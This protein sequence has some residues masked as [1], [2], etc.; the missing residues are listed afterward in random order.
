MDGESDGYFT[1]VNDPGHP[2]LKVLVRPRWTLAPPEGIGSVGKSKTPCPK[3]YGETKDNCPITMVLL[4]CWTWWRAKQ[5]GFVDALAVRRTWYQ[6]EL[7]DV[8]DRLEMVEF[9]GSEGAAGARNMIR[10]WLPEALA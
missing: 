8:I 2:N 4:K 6:N 7:R 5:G 10:D 3:D 1:V 9:D